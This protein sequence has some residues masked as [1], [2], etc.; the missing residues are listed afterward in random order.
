MWVE[1]VV[2]CFLSV[3]RFPLFSKQG[4]SQDFSKGGGGGGGGG[5]VTE[6]TH[7]ITIGGSPTTIYGLYRCFPSCISGLSRII[8]A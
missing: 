6:A 3:I 5:G 1:L 2:C 4:R 7:Q 8:A